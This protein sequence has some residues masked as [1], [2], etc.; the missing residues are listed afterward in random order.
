MVL[1]GQMALLGA[2]SPTEA[3][4]KGRLSRIATKLFGKVIKTEESTITPYSSP[5]MDFEALLYTMEDMLATAPS[6]APRHREARDMA[7]SLMTSILKFR[8][9]ADVRALIWELGMSPSDDGVLSV[10]MGL[11]FHSSSEGGNEESK[12]L[13]RGLPSVSVP[14]RDVAHLVSAI[15]SAPEGPL[16][17]AAIDELRRY[18]DKH[19]DDDLTSHLDNVSETFS[20]YIWEQLDLPVG[21]PS[22]SVSRDTFNMPMSARI[23][24]LRSRLSVAE[25]AA[26]EVGHLPPE[27]PN[28]TVTPTRIPTPSR[29]PKGGAANSH[30]STSALSLRERLAAAAQA[31]GLKATEQVEATSDDLHPLVQSSQAAALRARL[32]AVKRQSQSSAVKDIVDTLPGVHVDRDP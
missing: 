7:A 30:P 12:P 2:E 1:Q 31:S 19:G 20:E 26:P 3:A 28:P 27:R 4:F 25:V 6:G 16:R 24:D 11:D 22:K 21:S 29:I 5:D 15:G 32:Q 17:S 23:R 14:S 18:R 10:V 8:S 9:A 13:S